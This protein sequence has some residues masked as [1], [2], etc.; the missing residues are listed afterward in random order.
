MI[1]LKHLQ[2]GY[3]DMPVLHDISLC[4]PKGSITTL[5]GPNGCGKTTLL[6][7]LCGLLPV[8]GGSITIDNKDLAQYNRKEL[9]RKVAI[10]P[11]SRDIPALSVEMLVQHGRY[12]HLGLSRKL[13]KQDL[14]AVTD[15]MEKTDVAALAQMPLRQ[16]SGG[17]RQRAYIAMA[18]AQDAEI[19]L[20]D[21]PTT[22]LDLGRQFELLSVIQALQ[23][24]GKTLVMV[25]HDLDH[26]LR[27]SDYLVLLKEGRLVQAGT[28]EALLQSGALER[29]FDI[30]IRK[31]DG[32]FLFSPIQPEFT[33]Y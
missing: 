25:L 14:Q 13:T 2:A 20:L 18:L 1:R 9:A 33:E 8:S 24:A 22:H 26:A 10:L 19:I 30:T 3:T 29:V 27:Y 4:I 28:P 23:A 32:G 16:L 5:V 31:A 6:R 15:A 21:E 12:P 7:T 17:Q 11:Q